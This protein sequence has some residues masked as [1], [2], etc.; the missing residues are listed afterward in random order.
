MRVKNADQAGFTLAE[1]LLAATLGALLLAAAASTAGTFS[2][3]MAQLQT[4]AADSYEN[5]TACIDRDVRYAWMADVV[6]SHRLQVID[7]DN[8]VTEYHLVGN[9]LFVTRPDGSTGSVITG[10]DGLSFEEQTTQRLRSG[11]S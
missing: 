10:L 2:E 1:M 5:V 8:Q 3:S 4:E 6:D 7:T 11:S 9:S